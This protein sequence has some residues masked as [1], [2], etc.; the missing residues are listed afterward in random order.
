MAL[1]NTIV[2]R[3]LKLGP[4]HE[5][6]M[7]AKKHHSDRK[8]QTASRWS[9]FVAMATR[10]IALCPLVLLWSS[11][12]KAKAGIKHYVVVNDKGNDS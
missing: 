11:F 1:R 10:T 2:S 12:R 8:F 7:L 5:F 4:R 3:I 9:L 6:K